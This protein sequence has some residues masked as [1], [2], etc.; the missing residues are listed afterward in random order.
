MSN[1]F[2]DSSESWAIFNQAARRALED[3][4]FN[5][6]RLPGRGRSNMWNIERDGET[7]IASVRTSQD[8]FVAFPPLNN[9]ASWKTLDE[10]EKVVIA[11]VDDPETPENVEVYLFDAA[12]VRKRFDA[13]YQ[14]RRDAG[15]SIKNDF[16]MWLAIDV[17]DRD[18]PAAIGSGLVEGH[19]PIATFSIDELRPAAE[20]SDTV[21]RSKADSPP[22]PVTIADV[23]ARARGDIAMIASVSEN[24]IHLEI[25]IEF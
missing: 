6:E 12:E 20:V 16:G 4:R 17:D 5:V 11:T 2:E 1:G 14:A 19:P 15:H 9:G 18:T 21:P 13:S 7:V 3:A 23:L 10:A 25:K 24:A 22:A 8:R